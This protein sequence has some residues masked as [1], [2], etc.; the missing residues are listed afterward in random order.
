MIPSS[1]TRPSFPMLIEILHS[2]GRALHQ[3]FSWVP[4]HAPPEIC[5]TI[6]AKGQAISA[7]SVSGTRN[8]HVRLGSGIMKVT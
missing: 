4:S 5:Q 6:L 2:F 1:D 7:V 8:T 3:I